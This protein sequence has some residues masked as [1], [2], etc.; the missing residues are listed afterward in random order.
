MTA[1]IRQQR[2]GCFCRRV[3]FPEPFEM[4]EQVFL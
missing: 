2:M 3:D 4:L 1:A